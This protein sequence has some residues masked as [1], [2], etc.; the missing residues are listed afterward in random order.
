MKFMVA[1]VPALA[2]F[3][4]PLAPGGTFGPFKFERAGRWDGPL[5]GRR[6]GGGNRSI[7]E[8]PA[9]SPRAW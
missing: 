6:H 4:A 7:S 3:G 1:L 8:I 9:L 5:S 2:L